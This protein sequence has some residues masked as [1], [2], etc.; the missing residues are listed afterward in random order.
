VTEARCGIVMNF[1]RIAPFYRAMEAVTA[2][3]KLQRCR[4]A[5]LD[6]IPAPRRVLIAGEGHGRFL[7]EL[8][9]RFPEASVTVV[10]SS[11]KMLNIARSK[12][13]E[14]KVEFIHADLREWMP[15][16][17]NFDLIVTH[18]F[19]DCFPADELQ[20]V[21]DQLGRWATPEAHWLL[22]DFQEASGVARG[23]RSRLILKLLYRFFRITCNL[24][25]KHLSAPDPHLL[26]AGFTRHQRISLD[27]DLLKAEWWR[28][29]G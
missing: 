12:V 21:I 8:F 2:G 26:T 10:D 7:P 9:C 18:F 24:S 28:R 14:S 15:E 22:A 3:G 5:F 6:Q 29:D 20:R 27:W 19:L 4:V 25:A 11:R 16:S 1:D 23:L 17:G 13:P